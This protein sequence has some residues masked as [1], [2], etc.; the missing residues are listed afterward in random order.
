MSS[1]KAALFST[2]L[3][4]IATLFVVVAGVAIATPVAVN[5]PPDAPTI[6][7]P[8]PDDPTNDDTPQFFFRATD[9]HPEFGIAFFCRI[10]GGSYSACSNGDT[11]GPLLEESHTFQVFARDGAG[12]DSSPADFTWFVDLTNPVASIDSGP[13]DPTNS[14]DA[15]FTISGTDNHSASEDLTFHCQLDFGPWQPCLSTSP[16]EYFGLDEGSHIIAVYATDEARNVSDPVFY[17]WL[18]DTTAPVITVDDFV[19]GGPDS[20]VFG[21]W[22]T[23]SV[24]LQEWTC[25][26]PNNPIA[27][28]VTS[29]NLPGHGRTITDDGVY[30]LSQFLKPGDPFFC[31]DA[32]GN[33]AVISD[34][35]SQIILVDRHAP[36]CNVEPLSQYI[37]E[38]N[39]ADNGARHLAKFKV[40]RQDGN[41]DKKGITVVLESVVGPGTVQGMHIGTFDKQGKF[42]G[43]PGGIYFVTY[44]VT[45][46]AGWTSTCTG[47]VQ[48]ARN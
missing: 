10:D 37:P 31:V 4:V 5:T 34:T 21:T 15:S 47:K 20:Y 30:K 25:V 48:V 1:F 35:Q 7:P 17:E 11:F 36:T 29:S 3:V 32:A 40:A 42:E 8:R 12:S 27:S 44:R 46:E 45:D 13:L 33:Q 26:D 39:P 9:D 2:Q 14:P 28:G 18:I 43:V 38:N 6:D 24:R 41:I 19:I 23:G 16:V 22:A